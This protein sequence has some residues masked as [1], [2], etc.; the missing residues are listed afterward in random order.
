M[1]ILIP[2]LFLDRDGVIIENRPDYIRSWSDVEI[3]PQ[4]M[5]ALAKIKNSP[6]K[7]IIITNQS[8]V[9]RGLMTI[10]R[11]DQI[12]RRLVA[13]I[14]KVGGR[15]DGIYMCPHG[16]NQ[17]C[18]C[19]KPKPGLLYQAADD[20]NLDLSRSI[21]I[22]D[23]IS[24]IVAAASAGLSNLILVQTGRGTNQA[25]LP[26]VQELPDFLVYKNLSEAIDNLQDII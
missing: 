13:E 20:L 19:R 14:E 2:A 12:N 26:V 21:M 15:I 7:I 4:A 10:E 5:T 25:N 9:G 18:A 6:Y 1:E 22:G 16:P 11:A 3:Y 8:A 24:D 17:G 23:A